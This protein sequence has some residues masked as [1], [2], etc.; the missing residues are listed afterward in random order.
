MTHVENVLLADVGHDTD[1][2]IEQLLSMMTERDFEQ[3][4]STLQERFGL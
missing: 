3:L 1:A 4:K 2:R